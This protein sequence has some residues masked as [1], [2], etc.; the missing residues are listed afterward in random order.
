M[1]LGGV[2]LAGC[3]CCWVV[4]VVCL[5]PLLVGAVVGV[6]RL[7]IHRRVYPQADLWR[8]DA[9]TRRGGMWA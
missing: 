7:W 4:V 2:G 5:A 3:S 1:F 8:R 9:G 6:P